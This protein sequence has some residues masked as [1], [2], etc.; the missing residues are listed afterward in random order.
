MAKIK[1]KTRPIYFFHLLNETTVYLI[2]Q[3]GSLDIA[4]PLF[5]VGS[6]C[7]LA[8]LPMPVPC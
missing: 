6:E 5:L 3:A 1:M 7:K 8:S 4:H 2:T